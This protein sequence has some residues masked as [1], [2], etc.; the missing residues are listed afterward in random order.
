MRNIRSLVLGLVLVSLAGVSWGEGSTTTFFCE[1]NNFAQSKADGEIFQFSLSMKV[2]IEI[3]KSQALLTWAPVG[4]NDSATASRYTVTQYY[5]E[6]NFFWVDARDDWQPTRL[7]T[8]KR[9]KDSGDYLAAIVTATNGFGDV[10]SLDCT[11]F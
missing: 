7:F 5:N 1:A 2:Q 8:I 6:P 3:E 4:S 11:K 10:Q 9:D